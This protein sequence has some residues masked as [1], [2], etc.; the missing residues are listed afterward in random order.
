MY[1]LTCCS[2]GIC[3]YRTAFLL[4]ML[5]VLRSKGEVWVMTGCQALAARGTGMPSIS[6]KHGA[7]RK[8]CDSVTETA[9]NAA[10]SFLVPRHP[11]LSRTV[12]AQET[13]SSLSPSSSS[14][15]MFR[16]APRLLRIS[17]CRTPAV[18][19]LPYTRSAQ[20]QLLP[21]HRRAQFAPALRQFSL[22]TVYHGM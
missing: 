10:S 18:A 1:Q 5:V 19:A 9:S 22:T 20:R 2:R 15:T 3:T 12:P 7:L 6:D 21:V 14:V 4:A 13:T 16:A 17:R 11:F 8:L